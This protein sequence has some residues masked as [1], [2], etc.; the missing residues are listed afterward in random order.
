MS[1]ELISDCRLY[2]DR[3]IQPVSLEEIMLIQLKE[4]AP[5][6]RF[7]M[8]GP[9]VATAV[10]T[11][12]LLA[13]ALAIFV[14]PLDDPLATDPTPGA[15]G[16]IVD[17]VISG[18]EDGT[19]YAVGIDDRGSICAA[20]GVKTSTQSTCGGD[21]I[22]ATAYR[23]GGQ[24]IV[25]GYAPEAMQRLTLIFEDG[26]SVPLELTPIPNK[27]MS[28]FGTVV[29]NDARFVEIEGLDG[30]GNLLIRYF[31]SIGPTN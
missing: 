2:L 12:A 24:I 27:D 26:D 20:A 28:A 23:G 30:Q 3:V 7:S 29:S 6:R 25:A 15:G 22:N 14:G 17:F 9:M 18:E 16:V 8:N 13:G 10:A 21:G 5:P 19:Q 4:T 11:V 1:A 31:P